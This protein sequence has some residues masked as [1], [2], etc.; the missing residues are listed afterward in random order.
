MGFGVVEPNYSKENLE[1]KFLDKVGAWS[2][3][4]WKGQKDRNEVTEN[5]IKQI[6]GDLLVGTQT[7]DTLHMQINMEDRVLSFH[8]SGHQSVVI[9]NLPSILRPAIVL[10]TQDSGVTL[11]AT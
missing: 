9:R 1:G 5:G 10:Y 7:G 8:K 2:V 4:S 6:T 3:G 11:L